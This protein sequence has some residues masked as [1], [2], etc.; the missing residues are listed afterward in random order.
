MDPDERSVW[1]RGGESAYT[2]ML[3]RISNLDITPAQLALDP[4]TGS[5]VVTDVNTG[6]VLAL[7][8]YPGYNNNLMANGVD[9]A[10]YAKLRSDNSNPLYNYATQQKTAPGSTFKMVSATQALTK[11]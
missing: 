7:V 9:A 2:F 4:C 10:Y 5:M 3:N 11:A 1:E 8:S 6:D